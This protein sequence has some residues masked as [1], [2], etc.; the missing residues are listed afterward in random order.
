MAQLRTLAVPI[1]VLAAVLLFLLVNPWIVLD[2]AI[3]QIVTIGFWV[4][5]IL[6]LII[7]FSLRDDPDAENIEVEGPTFTR[8]L[9]SNPRAGLFW[10]PIRLFVGFAW[11]EAGWHKLNESGLDRRP[12][13]APRSS[14]SGRTRWRSPKRATRRS[15]TSGIGRSSS[16]SSTTAPRSW[17]TY[18]IP[19]G[20]FAVGLGLIFGVLTG[21]AAFFGALLNMTFLLGG[22]RVDEPDHVHARRRADA[23]LE[24]RRLLRPGSLPAAVARDALEEQRH[25]QRSGQNP[26]Q[27]ALPAVDGRGGV[28]RR[29]RADPGAVR[30]AHGHLPRPSAGRARVQDEELDRLQVEH[31]THLRSLKRRGVLLANGPLDEQTD[32]SYRGIGIYGVPLDEALAMANTDPMVKAG[33]LAV[34]GARW[35]TAAGEVIIPREAT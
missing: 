16:S 25:P 1:G 14:G 18:V 27:P 22:I 32:V 29:R 5:F 30:R 24:G 10:L 12:R 31:L 21:F 8:Y 11:L 7:L 34:K 2:G 23:R 20:E 13:P 28:P 17:M 26:A 3:S 35:L 4:S 15:P 33:R 19:I 6:L 9:F